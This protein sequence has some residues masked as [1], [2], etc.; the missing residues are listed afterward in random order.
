MKFF[1]G[2][3]PT[4][5]LLIRKTKARMEFTQP[6]GRISLFHTIVFQIV[7]IIMRFFL[8]KSSQHEHVLLI[9]LF[10]MIIIINFL[11]LKLL[12]SFFI[13]TFDN[14]YL[15]I[16]YPIFKLKLISTH[17]IVINRVNSPIGSEQV[18]LSSL[19]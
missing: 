12:Q 9:N 14:P 17:I 13:L 11:N 15:I 18:P 5:S 7:K 2:V 1:L 4:I 8:L 10:L 16:Q 6:F 3:F 19:I